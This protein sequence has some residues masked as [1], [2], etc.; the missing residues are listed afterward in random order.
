MMEIENLDANTVEECIRILN[1]ESQIP[2]N[3][4]NIS[5]GEDHLFSQSLTSGGTRNES[6]N[7]LTES[8]PVVEL[9]MENDQRDD[10]FQLQEVF[11]EALSSTLVENVKDIFQ[12][13][14]G[15]LPNSS[16]IDF[17]KENHCIYPKTILYL[18][19]QKRT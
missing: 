1:C 12:D 5:F 4:S 9:N 6:L 3:I 11:D 17:N 13:V 10:L 2:P 19:Y 7:P 8:S 15:M 16:W 18:S 14:K